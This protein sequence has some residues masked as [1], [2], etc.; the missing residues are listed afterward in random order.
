MIDQ[1]PIPPITAA[2]AGVVKQAYGAGDYS[3]AAALITMLRLHWFIRSRWVFLGIAV[4]ALLLERMYYPHAPRP[5][6]G[7]VL[8][9]TALG[10]CN[11]GWMI[12]SHFIFLRY[13]ETATGGPHRPVEIFAN[14]QVALDLLL[15]TF[16]LRFT[17]GIESPLALF[18]LFHITTTALLLRPWQACLQS[19]WAMLLYAVLAIGELH[20]W[21]VPHYDFLPRY[22][23][24]LYENTRYASASILV[25]GGGIAGAL[26]ITLQIAKRMQKR[27]DALKLA[28]EALDRSQ[29]A[30]HDLQA[31]RSRFMQLA[32]HQLKSPLAA[33]QT[34]TELI[35]G[36]V[37]PPE[38]VVGTCEKIINRCRDGIAQVTEL[39]TLARVQ[40]ADPRRHAHSIADVRHVLQKLFERY[41]PIAC[42]KRIDFTCGMPSDGNIYVLV[43]QQDLADCVGNLIENA[44]KYTPKDGRISV[45]FT[46]E[47]DPK[48]V[49]SER[50][51][52]SVSDTGIGINPELLISN[53]G[54]LGHAP[55]FDAFRR[56]NNAITA[57]IP[58]S[59][60]G[61][62]IVREVVEQAGGQIH[63][64]TAPNQGSTFS[65]CFPARRGTTFP[66]SV[67][68]TRAIEVNSRDCIVTDSET[69][70]SS[71]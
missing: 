15:L 11:V 22:S 5:L 42:E 49:Q 24:G 63:V 16:I 29:R 36:A 32:A 21:I 47:A 35:R 19:L 48:K 33:I 30:I 20:G 67:R 18:Y 62:S 17:G 12:C 56:G 66:L 69:E 23:A 64:T 34:M 13:Q 3:R 45:V 59:G 68:D 58:G 41:H 71:Q 27:E 65:V 6:A 37:I 8:T 44:I 55:V 53:D 38:A 51:L 4:I 40:E 54:E 60:L 1:A 70:R 14:A 52:I 9:L 10:L 26:F 2:S 43:D 61:L 7:L 50:V 28:N 31:R 39:L 57:G 25:V 46:I